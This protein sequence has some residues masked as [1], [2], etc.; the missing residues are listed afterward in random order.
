[1]EMLEK[2]E[3]KQKF[4]LLCSVCWFC[5]NDLLGFIYWFIF[6]VDGWICEDLMERFIVGIFNI[7]FDFNFCNLNLCVLVQ[8]VCE[9]VLEVGG[10]LFEFLLMLISENLVKFSVFLFCNLLVM[11]VEESICG[12]FFDVVVLMGGCDKIQFGLFMGVVSVN[13]FVI[14]FNSGLGILWLVIGGYFVMVY[15]VWCFVD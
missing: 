14:V 7:W 15:G 10:I 6:V 12:Y 9:G 11:D 8:K 13:V 4:M 5:K 1:M 3:E 2:L